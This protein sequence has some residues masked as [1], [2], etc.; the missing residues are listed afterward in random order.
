MSVAVSERAGPVGPGPVRC[1]RVITGRPVMVGAAFAAETPALAALSAE[2]FGA[3]RL[4]SAR[5]APR[6]ACRGDAEIGR[7]VPASLM[8]GHHIGG[9]DVADV[10]I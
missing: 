10:L 8:A 5:V 9:N 1:Q 4:L 6:A 3:A 7:V 2:P